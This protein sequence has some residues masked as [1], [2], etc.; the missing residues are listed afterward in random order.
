MTELLEDV[1]SSRDLPVLIAAARLL[2]EHPGRRVDRSALEAATGRDTDDVDRAL[3]NLNVRY[4]DVNLMMASGGV[5]VRAQVRS[6]T[7]A[8]L[9][10]V[11]QW[12][13]PEVA[14]DRLLAALDELIART[15]D[16]SPK[17]S[18]LKAAR[19]SLLAAGRDVLVGVAG[20]AITGR[21]PL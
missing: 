17:Q 3:V 10:T 16:G 6:I 14:A 7:E 4:L 13:S 5:I 1:W 19:E 21:L 15:A 8:G 11:G 12:P 9:R 20:A 2:N 18:K